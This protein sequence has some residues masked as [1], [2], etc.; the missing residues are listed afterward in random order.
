MIINNYLFLVISGFNIVKSTTTKRI[1]LFK[2]NFIINKYIIIRKDT[3]YK[4]LINYLY[5]DSEYI[6][7]FIDLD[8]LLEIIIDTNIKSRFIK[9]NTKNINSKI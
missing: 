7:V 8:F 4:S 2:Y 9:V 3:W 1:L 5:S 6:I